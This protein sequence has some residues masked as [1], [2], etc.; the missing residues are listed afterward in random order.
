MNKLKKL[1]TQQ[2]SELS[3][4]QNYLSSLEIKRESIQ[5]NVI[6]CTE[7]DRSADA[8]I[9]LLNKESLVNED[10]KILLN[11]EIKT[12]SNEILSLTPELDKQLKKYSLKKADFDHVQKKYE[13]SQKTLDLIQN[14]RWDAEREISA[15]KSLLVKTIS[16][17]D[18]KKN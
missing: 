9:Q 3:E 18:E 10:K 4:H 8:N 16:L 1:Y 15:D 14:R 6:V 5:N 13:D 7:K 12:Y 2:Q 17:V 11:N